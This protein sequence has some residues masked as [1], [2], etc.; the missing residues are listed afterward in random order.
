MNKLKSFQ[1]T[2]FYPCCGMDVNFPIKL[3]GAEDTRFIFCDKRSYRNWLEITNSGIPAKFLR[4][5]AW[6]AINRLPKINILFYRRDGMGEGGSG[7]EILGDD[8][9]EKLFL[10]FPPEGG[11]IITDGSNAFGHRL[12]ELELGLVNCAGFN[13]SLSENQEFEY[14]ELIIFDVNS[15]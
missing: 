7:L 1:K 13:I 11:R 6:D 3:L 8:Y 2:V 9:L 5:D 10:K 4:M 14:H 15:A 12:D